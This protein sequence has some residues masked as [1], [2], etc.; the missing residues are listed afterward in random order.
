MGATRQI[1]NILF[2]LSGQSVLH[3][4]AALAA[5]G[6]IV[7]TT[8]D[9]LKAELRSLITDESDRVINAVTS[10]GLHSL[11]INA[12][13]RRMWGKYCPLVESLS[14]RMFGDVLMVCSL[15]V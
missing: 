5:I 1:F 12:S 9:D 7:G 10:V 14:S 2:G 4:P 8:T 3:N 11:L 15:Q 6:R 13:M